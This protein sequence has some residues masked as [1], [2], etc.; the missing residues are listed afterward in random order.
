[1]GSQTTVLGKLCDGDQRKKS[2]SAVVLRRT[3]R[4]SLAGWRGAA[5][6]RAVLGRAVYRGWIAVAHRA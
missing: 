6:K 1:M 3:G 4:W 2:L 5:E